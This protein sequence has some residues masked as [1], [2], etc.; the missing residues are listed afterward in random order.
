MPSTDGHDISG[1]VDPT[2]LGDGPIEISLPNFPY[3]IDGR[4]NGTTGPSD[5]EFPF[6]LDM[7]SGNTIGIG[8]RRI[9]SPMTSSVI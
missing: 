7:N 3:E 5:S 8:G 6:N 2:L 4:V 1:Q 9:S